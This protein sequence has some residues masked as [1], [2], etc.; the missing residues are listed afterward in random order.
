MV[1][2]DPLVLAAC[3]RVIVMQDGEIITDGPYAD[4]IENPHFR[5][6]VIEGSNNA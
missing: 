3:D 2:N 5:R 4:V 1:S 6:C